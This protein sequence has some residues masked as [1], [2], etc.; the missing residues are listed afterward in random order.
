[1][2][3]LG[4]QNLLKKAETIVIPISFKGVLCHIHAILLLFVA[5]V[6]RELL[7]KKYEKHLTLHVDKSK[8]KKWQT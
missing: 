8:H 3:S 5:I 2:P 7:V 1:M 6:L 4:I